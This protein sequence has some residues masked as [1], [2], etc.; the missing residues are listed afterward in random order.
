MV[1]LW[2]VVPSEVVSVDCEVIDGLKVIDFVEVKIVVVTVDK[3]VVLVV[4][5]V[6]S[7]GIM[8]ETLA[9]TSLAPP[10]VVSTVT[11]SYSSASAKDSSSVPGSK[12]SLPEIEY[13]FKVLLPTTGPVSRVPFGSSSITTATRVVVDSSLLI[14]PAAADDVV[15]V[16]EDS[17]GRIS[18]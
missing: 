10:S 6:L 18:K 7:D 17:V 13:S 8:E 14:L 9:P 16:I 1:G 15:V 4:G 3:D 11:T 2:I 5:V 12:L